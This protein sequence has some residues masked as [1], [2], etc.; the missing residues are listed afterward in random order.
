VSRFSSVAWITFLIGGAI[1]AHGLIYAC[2][3]M[4]GFRDLY[5]F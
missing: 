1:V 4:D 3:G 2:T 5:L